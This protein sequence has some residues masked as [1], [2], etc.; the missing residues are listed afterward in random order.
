MALRRPTRSPLAGIAA[1]LGG[2]GVALG[3]FGAHALR[4]VLDERALGLWQTAV[5]YQVWHALA[6]LFVAG[7]LHRDST[8]LRR[9]AAALLLTGT[10]LFCASLFALALGAPRPV[11]L[12][13]PLGGIAMISGWLALAWSLLAP[14]PPT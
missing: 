11:G 7:L 6:L 1:L 9:I 12:I 10:L 2:S 8:T 4:G 3:A 14:P 13:T 5:Q